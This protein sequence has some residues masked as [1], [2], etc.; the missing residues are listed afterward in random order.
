MSSFIQRFSTA[1]SRHTWHALNTFNTIQRS[2]ALVIMSTKLKITIWFLEDK[3]VAN[4]MVGADSEEGLQTCSLCSSTALWHWCFPLSCIQTC[5]CLPIEVAKGRSRSPSSTKDRSRSPTRICNQCAPCSLQVSS[6]GALVYPQMPDLQLL[7]FYYWSFWCLKCVFSFWCFWCL[8]FA[9][10]LA[11]CGIAPS[12]FNLWLN[13]V[14]V[15]MIAKQ[16][17]QCQL[18]VLYS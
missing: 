13:L 12:Q 3:F 4:R 18:N 16:E 7:I 8:C 15:K 17:E 10:A 2:Q 5:I 9:E 1:L 11:C 6:D 14:C